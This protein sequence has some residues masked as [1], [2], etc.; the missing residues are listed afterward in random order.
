MDLDSISEK[1]NNLMKYKK[2]EVAWIMNHVEHSILWP[3]YGS[4]FAKFPAV[5]AIKI[6]GYVPGFNDGEPCVFGVHGPYLKI[7]GV[8]EDQCDD[9]GGFMDVYFGPMTGDYYKT[10]IKPVFGPVGLDTKF[11][12]TEWENFYKF[13]RAH[14]EQLEWLY[15]NNFEVIATR[16]GVSVDREFDCGY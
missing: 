7:A 8:P 12:R 6:R 1:L 16:D 11:F 4:F 15:S 14:E 9:D 13:I 10:Y 2:A 5:Q 3:L